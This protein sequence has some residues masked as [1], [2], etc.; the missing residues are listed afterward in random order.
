LV[1]RVFLHEALLFAEQ[2]PEVLFG[3]VGVGLVVVLVHV[4]VQQLLDVQRLVFEQLQHQAQ[5]V[6]GVVQATSHTENSYFISR[7]ISDWVVSPLQC[8][9]LLGQHLRTVQVVLALD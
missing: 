1:A 6:D 2:H 4:A 3:L 5:I 9:R 7:R 8:R